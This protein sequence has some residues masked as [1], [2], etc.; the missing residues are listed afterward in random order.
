MPT[1]E[2]KCKNCK[3]SVDIFHSITADH[4]K[5]CPNCKTESLSRMIGAGSGIIFKG[6][7]FYETDYKDKKGVKKE[8]SSTKVDSSNNKKE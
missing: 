6:S 2:Y 4:V 7:G 1:Y 3:E 8:S 5:E